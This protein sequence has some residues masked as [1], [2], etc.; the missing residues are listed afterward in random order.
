[1]QILLNFT[2][3]ELEGTPPFCSFDFVE[4]RDGGYETSPLI[5]KFCGSQ[6]PP[7][8]VSHSNRLWI[9]FHSDPSITSHG[10]IAHWDGTQTGTCLL[11]SLSVSF[12]Y[13]VRLRS[14]K[15]RDSVIT[16]HQTILS[17]LV[18]QH[19]TFKKGPLIRFS[20]GIYSPMNVLR[21]FLTVIQLHALLR[22]SSP[23]Y[24]LPYHPNAECYWNIRTSQGSQV[25]LSF[26]GFHL[27]SSSSCSY[28]Y[29]AVHDGNSSTAPELAKL[30]GTELPRPINSS[31]NQLYIKLRTD[32]SVNTG[33]FIAFYNTSCGGDVGGPN[34]SIS[35]PGYPNKYPDNRECIWYITTT[36]GSS[37]T[38]TIHEFDVEFHDN[39]NYD[40]LEVSNVQF[41][42]QKQSHSS[43]MLSHGNGSACRVKLTQRV[44]KSRIEMV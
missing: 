9:R 32:S 10:F 16:K 29:L 14:Q 3:F 24:P 42:S 26:S 13:T 31:S 15:Y 25:Q 1:M 2:S 23:N 19:Q 39:C 22:L 40:V 27:E 21:F 30:C 35:S 43:E 11:Y 7:V 5:G 8:V 38:L 17:R 18:Q 20:Q 33:G 12:I 36:P 6:R 28:D 34:G 37:I 41:L 44:R 4:I